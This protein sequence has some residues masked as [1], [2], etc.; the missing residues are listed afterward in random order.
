MLGLPGACS[1]EEDYSRNR[2]DKSGYACNMI[3]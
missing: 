1:D 3:L 2:K